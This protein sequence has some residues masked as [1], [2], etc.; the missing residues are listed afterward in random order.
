MPRTK[1]RSSNHAP[2]TRKSRSRRANATRQ[3]PRGEESAK[4]RRY[5]DFV[6]AIV[7]ATSRNGR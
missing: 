2:S 4:I 6:R 3:S 7:G 5:V 1:S